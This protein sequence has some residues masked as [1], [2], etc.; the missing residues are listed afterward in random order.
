M[1]LRGNGIASINSSATSIL[2]PGELTAAR[3]FGRSKF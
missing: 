2:E 3:D 1:G